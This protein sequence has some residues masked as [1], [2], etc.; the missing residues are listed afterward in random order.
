MICVFYYILFYIQISDVS[1]MDKQHNI[2]STVEAEQNIYKH[3]S[4]FVSFF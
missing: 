2:M 1:H 3:N 4:F